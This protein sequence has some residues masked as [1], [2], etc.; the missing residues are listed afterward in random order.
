MHLHA[1]DPRCSQR[2]RQHRFSTR[3]LGARSTASQPLTLGIQ[4]MC[5][6]GNAW[7]LQHSCR[8]V[9]Q[10]SPLHPP[11]GREEGLS[12]ERQLLT[13]SSRK[14]PTRLR[15]KPLRTPSISCATASSSC[16]SSHCACRSRRST[17]SSALSLSWPI[18]PACRR[19]GNHA[20]CYRGAVSSRC[21]HLGSSMTASPDLALMC[22]KRPACR[23]TAAGQPV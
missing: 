6:L 11:T 16:L 5:T 13:S 18:R 7:N 22:P 1:A 21:A 19:T 15:L 14:S 4:S 9:R 20:F 10:H 17:S 12:M 3:S 23:H 8:G 2:P